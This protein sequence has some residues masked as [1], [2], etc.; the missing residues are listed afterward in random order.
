[1]AT[2]AVIGEALAVEGYALAGVV[3]HPAD[4]PGEATAAFDALPPGT[5]LVI[6]TASAAGWLA[7]RL[8]QRPDILTVV[9]EP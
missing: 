2:A 4:S 5:A 1:V 3:V 8:G 6:V 9:M 7:D